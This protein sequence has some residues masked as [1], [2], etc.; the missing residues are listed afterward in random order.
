MLKQGSFNL[1]KLE[2]FEMNWDPSDDVSNTTNVFDKHRSGQNVAN[3][4]RAIT[5]TMLATHFGE[6]IINPLFAKYA[7]HVADH[8]ALEKTKYINLVIS[9]TKK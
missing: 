1:D 2:I 7:K 5:E 9:M 3:C 4:I 6:G 8:L